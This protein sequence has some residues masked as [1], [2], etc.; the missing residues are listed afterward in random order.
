MT[1]NEA[2]LYFNRDGD[3]TAI[4][5]YTNNPDSNENIRRHVTYDANRPIF[6][7]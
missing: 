4:E 6:M 7:I 3:E 1:L 2:Q 5:V